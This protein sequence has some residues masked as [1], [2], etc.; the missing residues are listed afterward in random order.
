MRRLLLALCAA[1][2]MQAPAARA[3][4]L[5]PSPV[6]GDPLVADAA[7]YARM[8]DV[9][10]DEA[11]RRLRAQEAS[12][13]LVDSLAEANRARLAGILVEHRPDY[14][15]VIVVT[16]ATATETPLAI[17]PFGVPVVLRTGAL[18]TRDATLAAIAAH[19]AEIRAALPAPPGLGVDPAT[20]ALLVLVRRRDLSDTAALT[21][22]LEAIAGVPVEL[23]TAGDVARNLSVE[24]G[25]RVVGSFVPGGQRYA[26]TAGF[27]VTDGATTALTTAAHCPDTLAFVEADGTRTPLTLLGAWGAGSQDV[28]LHTAEAPLP[29]LFHADDAVVPR[30][31]AISRTRASTRAG[32][33][34]C[35]RGQRTAYSCSVVQIVD[36]APPGELCAGPCPPTWVAVAG[37]ACGTGDSGGPVFLGTTAFGL[38]KGDTTEDGTCRL[39]YYM[40]VD[41]LPPD[42]TVLTG[43]EP[44]L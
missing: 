33:F 27:V 42:W 19:Q 4:Q 17:A 39:Y 41:H 28:Q 36:Y 1:L 32:D 34:V 3:A 2:L 13:P 10:P 31:L 38:M 15:I 7:E 24:G 20:G 26:C 5:E 29:P 44:Q 18:A 43:L 9:A 30:T 35:H 6:A 8:F 40:S 25:G 14:R 23:S 11:L 16:G 37:P 21:A 12:V 22:R